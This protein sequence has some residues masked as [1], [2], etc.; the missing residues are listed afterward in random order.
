[1]PYRFIR[2]C[3]LP[4][5]HLLFRKPK[6]LEAPVASLITDTLATS[7]LLCGSPVWNRL[8]QSARLLTL[9][10]A[11]R[12]LWNARGSECLLLECRTGSIGTYLLIPILARD[13]WVPNVMPAWL[14]PLVG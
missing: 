1:M 6:W 10:E 12:L 9:P 13:N 11:T 8:L 14:K 5:S 7:S 4:K 3:P 2:A